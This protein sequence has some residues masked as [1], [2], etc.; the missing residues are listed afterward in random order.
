MYECF[1][2]A[3]LISLKFALC[4]HQYLYVD[5]LSRKT[6]LKLVMGWAEHV[7]LIKSTYDVSLDRYC[8]HS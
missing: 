7:I 2:K 8:V 6:L 1:F 4:K 3:S 5:K